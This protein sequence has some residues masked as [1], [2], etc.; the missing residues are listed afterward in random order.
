MKKYK[1]FISYR[2]THGNDADLV[3]NTLVNEHNF[4]KD[5]I[6]LDKHNIGPEK[7]DERIESSINESSA[8]IIIVTI[9]CFNPKD[10]D[11]FIN[12][13]KLALKNKVT[14]I[15]VFFD[16]LKDFSGEIDN[17]K[18]SFTDVEIDT[19]KKSQGVIYDFNFSEQTFST[20]T[21]FVNRCYLKIG[22]RKQKM[23]LILKEVGIWTTIVTVLLVLSFSL[24]LGL[25]LLS[26]YLFTSKNV[27]KVLK[28]N[29]TVVG[30]T[31]YFEFCGLV[32]KYDL[33][34]DSISVN[35]TVNNKLP[36]QPY[37]IFI[38]SI[39]PAGA[40]LL[41]NKNLNYL[42]YLSYFRGGG[43]HRQLI[44]L[45]TCAIVCVG[46]FCGFSQGYQL[47]KQLKQKDV[48]ENELQ[49]QLKRR[50]TWAVVFKDYYYANLKY[51]KIMNNN[52]PLD[53]IQYIY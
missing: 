39:S 31:A 19:L 15:P 12:E 26:G 9:G 43:K 53:P 44:L 45:G 7:F 4:S 52:K 25:G 30:T 40:I 48:V 27:D 41:L 36:E 20:L 34:E 17:L 10:D 46:S 37:D 1:A 16:G 24:F 49:F 5:E 47:A 32:A 23:I 13:I 29:T 21:D 28:D 50:E 18:I 11:W 38:Q 6:F 14:I 33:D 35:Y 42:K 2:K 51:K 3:K 22:D 8:L